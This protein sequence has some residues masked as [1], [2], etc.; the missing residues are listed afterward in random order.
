MKLKVRQILEIKPSL[1]KILEKELPSKVLFRYFKMMKLFME[2]FDDFH[3]IRDQKLE[4]YG[5]ALPEVMGQPKQYAFETEEKKISFA[6]EIEDLLNEE[7]DFGE[8]EKIKQSDLES[9]NIELSFTDM[10]KL[11]DFIDID[12]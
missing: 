8:V 5:Q 4:E 9:S 7:V 3:K 12:G 1:E 10:M 2:S 11:T 6:K